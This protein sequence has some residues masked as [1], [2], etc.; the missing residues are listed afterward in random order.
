MQSRL[1]VDQ[2]ALLE[3]RLADML[4]TGLQETPH[5]LLVAETARAWIDLNRDPREIDPAMIAHN[6]PSLPQVRRETRTCDQSRIRAGLGLL[7]SRVPRIGEIYRE[8]LTLTDIQD[9]VAR[10]HATWHSAIEQAMHAA[11]SA[12]GIAIL[13]DLHSMPTIPRGQVG[14][15]LRVV[16]GDRHGQS[17]ETGLAE[18][19]VTL[20]RKAG[21]ASDLNRPYAGAYTL[22]RHGRPRQDFHAIQLEFDRALYLND[23]GEIVK[24]KVEELRMLLRNLCDELAE[25]GSAL[26]TAQ[27]AE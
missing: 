23:K 13:V 2:L 16:V 22:A 11:W 6:D 12:H 4:V 25:T 17:C 26:T 20:S 21:L 9:R 24:T 1:T 15:G 18:S 7:P 19:V 10:V 27:A 3:D 14:H 5:Q 8:R